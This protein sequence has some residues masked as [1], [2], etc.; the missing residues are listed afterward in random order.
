MHQKPPTTLQAGCLSPRPFAERVVFPISR[1]ISMGS[2]VIL[3]R[4]DVVDFALGGGDRASGN[5]ASNI[6]EVQ[7]DPGAQRGMPEL[8]RELLD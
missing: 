3:G 5:G 7:F 1:V 2:S 4:V 8:L 6:A